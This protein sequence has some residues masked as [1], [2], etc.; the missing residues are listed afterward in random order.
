MISKLSR[1]P[2]KN[3]ETYLKLGPSWRN[4]PVWNWKDL[5]FRRFV[6]AEIAI[7]CKLQKSLLILPKIQPKMPILPKIQPKRPY[8][9]LSSVGFE[10]DG[11]KKQN[12]FGKQTKSKIFSSNF[13]E[14]HTFKIRE[15]LGP[16]QLI[17]RADNWHF[18]VPGLFWSCKR[19]DI[20]KHYKANIGTQPKRTTVQSWMILK[21]S[22]FNHLAGFS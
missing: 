14:I 7:K 22:H 11:S 15:T 16:S 1:P 5:G 8:I 21:E 9:Q 18:I 17:K 6:W 10:I 4:L 3:K 19:I 2:F 20:L 12:N 13:A